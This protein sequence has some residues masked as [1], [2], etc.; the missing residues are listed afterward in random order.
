MTEA[1]AL[2]RVIASTRVLRGG[3]RKDLAAAS[4]L[5]Y[6]YLSE[7]EAGLKEPSLPALRLLAGALGLYPSELLARA[8]QLREDED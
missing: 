7:I 1:E 8:E 4:T 5:S 3:K 6:P 2:G